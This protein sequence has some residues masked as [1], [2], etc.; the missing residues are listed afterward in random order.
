VNREIR[1]LDELQQYV[2]AKR[3]RA[4]RTLDRTILLL[5]G[6]IVNYKDQGTP[7]FV[8]DDSNHIFLKLGGGDFLFSFNP[9][10]QSVQ[11]RERNLA[12]TVV[13][14]FNNSTDVSEVESFFENLI[15]AE[16]P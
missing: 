3:H 12:G 10:E 4:S 16:T 1:T 8:R 13:H 7:V 6:A 9:A 11:V 2:N 15:M 14:E 5:S